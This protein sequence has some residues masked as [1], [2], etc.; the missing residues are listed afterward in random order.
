M[1][2]SA[3]ASSSHASNGS[4]RQFITPV[5]SR[6]LISRLDLSFS[7]FSPLGRVKSALDDMRSAR[8]ASFKSTGQQNQ[9]QIK[10]RLRKSNTSRL[11]SQRQTSSGM[12]SQIHTKH[13]ILS[14]AASRGYS[15]TGRWKPVE[16]GSASR[17]DQS[18]SRSKPARY[19]IISRALC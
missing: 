17:S 15:T 12:R 10:S 3:S 4:H 14:D 13:Q 8:R 9:G 16:V 18:S 19:P 6:Q 7:L 11:F 2:S 1:P 5:T